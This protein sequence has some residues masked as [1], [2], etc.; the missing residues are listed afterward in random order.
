[1]KVLL[2][3]ADDVSA[4]ADALGTRP[5]WCLLTDP[6]VM[7]TV[8]PVASGLKGFLRARGVA[9]CEIDDYIQEALSKAAT[10]RVTYSTS[11]ELLAWCLPVARNMVIDESRRRK[12]RRHLMTHEEPMGDP[13]TEVLSRLQAFAVLDAM[14]QLPEADREALTTR[15]VPRDRQESNRLAQRRTRAR[16]RLR[17]LLAGAIPACW[18]GAR[19]L[20]RAGAGGIAV[21]SCVAITIAHSVTRLPESP[22]PAPA[23]RPTLQIR[24]LG[25]GAHPQKLKPHASLATPASHGI[26]RLPPARSSVVRRLVVAPRG[27]DQGVYVDERE[28]TSSDHLV[29]ADRVPLIG[30]VCTPK[31]TADIAAQPGGALTV[32]N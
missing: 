5:T 31:S 21:A 26:R 25:A 9:H 29:C 7:S 15:T 16:T 13:E 32:R 2:G 14:R 23:V 3:D 22:V 6:A 24:N 4:S 28:R 30:R 17:N 8:P 20:T 19:R 10:R 18:L 12:R 1:M 11:D 27:A